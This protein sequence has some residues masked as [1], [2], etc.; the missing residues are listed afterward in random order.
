M[1]EPSFERGKR[2][3]APLRRVAGF[4][5]IGCEVDVNSTSH[6]TLLV[7]RPPVGSVARIEEN[8]LPE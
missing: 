5:E 8:R 7:R 1:R 3:A 6:M 4:R 2:V